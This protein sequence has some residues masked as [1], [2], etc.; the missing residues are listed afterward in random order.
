MALGRPLK[1]ATLAQRRGTWGKV[2]LVPQENVTAT[3]WIQRT[4]LAYRVMPP[5]LSSEHSR[6]LLYGIAAELRACL[7]RRRSHRPALAYTAFDF[8]DD[9]IWRAALSAEGWEELSHAD[10]FHLQLEDKHDFLLPVPGLEWE[11]SRMPERP[12]PAAIHILNKAW[13]DSADPLTA[14]RTGQ[15]GAYL[16]DYANFKLEVHLG[17]A[18]EHREPVALVILGL[19]PPP[20]TELEAWILDLVVVPDCR[21][22][23]VGS[24]ALAQG[25]DVLRRSGVRKTFA[26]IDRHNEPSIRTHRSLGFERCDG[27]YRTYLLRHDHDKAELDDAGSGVSLS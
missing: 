5:Q 9:A 17:I 8:A 25:L 6:H 10:R 18:R 16:K 1:Q 14:V 21:H 12:S 20:A 26:L 22:R 23:G 3:V 19:P 27:P 7:Q 2:Q 4:H 15:P 13:S 11:W 24:M